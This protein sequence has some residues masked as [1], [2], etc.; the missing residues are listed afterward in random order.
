MNKRMKITIITGAILGVF[1]IVGATL[2]TS[3]DISNT[4]LFAFWF[5]RLLMGV[6]FGLLSV[7]LDLSKRL[8]RGF[9]LGLFVSFAFYVSTEFNDLTGFLAGGVYGVII[10]FVAYKFEVKK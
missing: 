9:I 6:L 3:G 7:N 1:C 4:Y 2:R 8:V 5:N 10:E